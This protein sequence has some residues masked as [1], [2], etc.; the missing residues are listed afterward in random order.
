MGVNL[1]HGQENMGENQIQWMRHSIRP[2][3]QIGGLYWIKQTAEGE[4]QPLYITHFSMEIM[5]PIFC[6][7][8]ES[9]P[10]MRRKL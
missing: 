8:Q 6:Q 3:Q 10:S 2:K 7:N 9:S 5:G 1:E 4:L